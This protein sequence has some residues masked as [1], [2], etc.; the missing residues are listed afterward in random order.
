MS[1][2]AAVDHS[3]GMSRLPDR[4][5]VFIA[6]DA[7]ALRARVGALL[8]T[9]AMHIVGEAAAPEDCIAGILKARPQVVVLDVRLA[10]GTGLQV[11]RAVRGVAPEIAFVAFSNHAAPAYRRRYLAEGALAFLDKSVDFE[12]L[13]QAI[14]EAVRHGPHP[15]ASNP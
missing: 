5:E 6:D 7:Q 9:S 8:R 15:F 12:R 14:A 2:R 13:P 1:R 10:G 11:L 3:D 4:I